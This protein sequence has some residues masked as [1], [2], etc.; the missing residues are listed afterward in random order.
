MNEGKSM[1]ITQM[2]K[3]ILKVSSIKY[4]IHIFRKNRLL[5]REHNVISFPKKIS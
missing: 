4:F 3:F 1:L 5:D 2:I